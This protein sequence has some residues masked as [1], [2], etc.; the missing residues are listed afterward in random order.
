MAVA[1]WKKWP[2]P[3]TTT[4]TQPT[5]LA[6][7]QPSWRSAGICAQVPAG[8][9]APA[10]PCGARGRG[11]HRY[12]YEKDSDET[13]IAVHRLKFIHTT[14]VNL[15]RVGA[16]SM[17]TVLSG[18]QILRGCTSTVDSLLYLELYRVLCIVIRSAARSAFL[19]TAVQTW[20]LVLNLVRP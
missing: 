8:R 16:V 11:E 15:V 18:S 1:K 20:L 3:A 7:R 4:L 5:R 2:A 9:V 6:A 19:K 17:H 12:Y 10:A 13:G 14:A